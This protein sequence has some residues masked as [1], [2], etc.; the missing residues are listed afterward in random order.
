MKH[1]KDYNNFLNEGATLDLTKLP[2]HLLLQMIEILNGSNTSN[3]DNQKALMDF[4]KE[5]KRRGL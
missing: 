1:V 2:D 4:A 5:K 3:P